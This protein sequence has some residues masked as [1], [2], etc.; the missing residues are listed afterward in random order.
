MCA[1]PEPSYSAQVFDVSFH[2][3]SF[4]RA[5][6]CG[7]V[8]RVRCRPT[9]LRNL[10]LRSTRIRSQRW[11]SRGSVARWTGDHPA[12]CLPRYRRQGHSQWPRSAFDHFVSFGHDFACVSGL[13]AF[14]RLRA[15]AYALCGWSSSAL[16]THGC[17]GEVCVC[18]H[19]PVGG[20]Q[21]CAS[22]ASHWPPRFRRSQ[23]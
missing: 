10:R 13:V 15:D 7:D 17:R 18:R 22:L 9:A 2:F 3:H 5:Q 16:S 21:S 14:T 1:M 20:P 11:G 4:V 8:P 19:T 23:L 12:P 6:S